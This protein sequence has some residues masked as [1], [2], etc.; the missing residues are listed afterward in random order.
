MNIIFD[1]SLTYFC[2]LQVTTNVGFERILFYHCQILKA[3][4]NNIYCLFCRI[5]CLL[6]MHWNFW[7]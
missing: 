5:N 7:A 1:D 4:M 6:E 2:M 3:E